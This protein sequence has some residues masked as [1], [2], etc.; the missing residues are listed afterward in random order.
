MSNTPHALTEE[1]PDKLD[2]MHALKES[3]AHFAKLMD[4][5]QAV[6]DEVHL[7]ETNV[8]PTDDLHETELRK[9]RMMLKD[10]I[11]RMLAAELAA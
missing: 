7:A 2:A 1:F 9:K 6:N 4:E 10:E 5:Y 3:N 8:A 11:A